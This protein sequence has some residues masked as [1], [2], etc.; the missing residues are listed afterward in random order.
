MK[1]YLKKNKRKEIRDFFAKD[2]TRYK[3]LML[4]MKVRQENEEEKQLFANNA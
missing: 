1:R 3:G 4:M 2:T